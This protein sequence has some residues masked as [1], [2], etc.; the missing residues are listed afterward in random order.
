MTAGLSP[1]AGCHRKGR[2]A[3]HFGTRRDGQ[4]TVAG[5]DLLARRQD[6]LQA[7]GAGA[8]HIQRA[9]FC[10]QATFHPDHPGREQRILVGW[11]GCGEHQVIKFSRIRARSFNTTLHNFRGQLGHG[12]VFEGPGKIPECGSH[13]GGDVDILGHWMFSRPLNRSSILALVVT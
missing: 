11:A 1:P 8:R 4:M 9:G 2:T 13:A 5:C 7:A 3:E 6:G 10:W 12:F